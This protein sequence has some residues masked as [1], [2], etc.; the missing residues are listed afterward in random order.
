MGLTGFKA[1]IKSPLC[2]TI[3]SVYQGPHSFHK[4]AQ[5]LLQL[6][7]ESSSSDFLVPLTKSVVL[8]QGLQE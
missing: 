5:K 1:Q 8:C 4:P 3:P 7:L 6:Q 2:D